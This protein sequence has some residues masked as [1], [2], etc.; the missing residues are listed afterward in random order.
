MKPETGTREEKYFA[1]LTE[2]K[3]LSTQQERAKLNGL[4]EFA[5]GPFKL[6]GAADPKSAFSFLG[7]NSPTCLCSDVGLPRMLR[8]P[9][10]D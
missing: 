1:N 2:Q 3:L 10:A 5:R 8:N 9:N 6:D 4:L 7:A